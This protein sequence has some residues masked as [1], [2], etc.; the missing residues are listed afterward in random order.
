MSVTLFS[1][2]NE[3][4]EVP[5]EVA[6][7]MGTVKS[8]MEGTCACSF[9]RLSLLSPDT[10]DEASIQLSNIDSKTLRKVVDYCTYHHQHSRTAPVQLFGYSF[11]SRFSWF[12]GSYTFFF[13]VCLSCE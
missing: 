6:K 2:E 9:S 5:V 11:R 8:M 12:L 13:F 3:K 4:F 7:F 1:K 10:G